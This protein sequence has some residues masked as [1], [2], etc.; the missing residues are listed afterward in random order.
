MCYIV[1]MYELL[2]RSLRMYTRYYNFLDIIKKEKEQMLG[3]IKNVLVSIMNDHVWNKTRKFLDCL[4]TSYGDDHRWHNS[5]LKDWY[6]VYYKN[7]T[8]NTMCTAG[9]LRPS[10]RASQ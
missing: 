2:A 6:S 4:Q 7:I 10:M 5:M 1:R 8:Q 3:I 9:A